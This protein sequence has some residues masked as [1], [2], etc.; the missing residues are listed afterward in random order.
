MEFT[1]FLTVFQ[2]L[3]AV[4]LHEIAHGVAAL[5]LG[6][7]TAKNQGRLTLN[8]IKHID[9]VMTI[10]LPALLILS[11]SPVVFGGAKPV[12]VNPFCFRNPKKG[13]A[14]VAVAG[15]L[16]NFVLCAVWIGCWKLTS[17]FPSAIWSDPLVGHFLLAGIFINLVLGLFNLIPIPPLDGGRI[18]VAFLPKTLAKALSRLEP[19]GF[20]LVF[21]LLYSGIVQKGLRV[22]MLWIESLL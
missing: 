16:T 9:L 4:I 17:A 7:P 20:F 2:L 12:P 5:M 21:A 15:P 18:A 10:I 1:Q 19:I 3:I 8:P 14:I 22:A 11:K 6:D 13:M